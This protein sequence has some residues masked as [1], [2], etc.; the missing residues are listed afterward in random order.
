MGK[1]DIGTHALNLP[2]RI[3]HERDGRIVDNQG[4]PVAF[5]SSTTSILSRE[6]ENGITSVAYRTTDTA[7][8]T[9]AK[10]IVAAVNAL[11][12]ADNG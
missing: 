2:W 3:D 4:I 8:A 9:R 11:Y 12:G 10:V 6:Q 5:G 1:P 7:S